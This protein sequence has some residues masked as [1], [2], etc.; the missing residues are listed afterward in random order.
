MGKVKNVIDILDKM[1]QKEKLRFGIT[2]CRSDYTNLIYDKEMIF[3]VFDR[4]LRKIDEEYATS[5]VNMRK[6]PLILFTMA[7]IMEM[8]DSEQNRV[9]FYLINCFNSI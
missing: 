7:K 2:M 8:S 9:L 3:N 6:Y 4:K 5:Y 1:D